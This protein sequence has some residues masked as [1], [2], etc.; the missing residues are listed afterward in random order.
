MSRKENIMVSFMETI[1]I[2]FRLELCILKKLL[3]MQISISIP[4]FLLSLNTV[5]GGR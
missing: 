2:F 3:I 1:L 5:N 4:F